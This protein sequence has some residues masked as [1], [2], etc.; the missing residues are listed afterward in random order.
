[1]RTYHGRPVYNIRPID[2]I[3]FHPMAH[4]LIDQGI[5]KGCVQ[6]FV[7]VIGGKEWINVDKNDIQAVS[8]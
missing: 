2:K 8:R 6:I 7:D 5:L 4:N 1:M 3:N